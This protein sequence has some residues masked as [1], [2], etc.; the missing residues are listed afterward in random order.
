MIVRSELYFPDIEFEFP[1]PPTPKSEDHRALGQMLKAKLRKDAKEKSQD[2]PPPS[3]SYS[4]SPLWSI[5]GVLKSM[6]AR[7]AGLRDRYGVALPMERV[8]IEFVRRETLVPRKGKKRNQL[9]NAY[10]Q[11]IVKSIVGLHTRSAKGD[12]SVKIGYYGEQYSRRQEQVEG[13]L[14]HELGH[15]FGEHPLFGVEYEEMKGYSLQALLMAKPETG[16]GATGSLVH[17]R[18][19]GMLA[20]LGSMGICEPAILAHVTG[21][22]FGEYGPQSYRDLRRF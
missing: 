2:S 18:S 12:H 22:S 11:D 13:T 1:D 17:D 8:D 19:R 7:L 21:I 14:A 15:V 6:D 3:V 20:Q 9:I 5:H 10:G 4:E 16:A